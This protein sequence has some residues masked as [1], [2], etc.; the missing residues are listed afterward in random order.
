MKRTIGEYLERMAEEIPL[1]IGLTIAGVGIMGCLA[2][3]TTLS[4]DFAGI[5]EP[6]RIGLFDKKYHMNSYTLSEIVKAA[7]LRAEG[8]VN[9]DR[10]REIVIKDGNDIIAFRLDTRSYF[11]QESDC[12]EKAGTLEGVGRGVARLSLEDTDKD[13][14]IDLLLNMKDNTLKQYSGKS[15]VK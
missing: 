9:G 2:I 6:H 13:G 4:Y 15:L 11:A 1:P 5:G 14:C 10:I 8:D 7:D 12:Y 3:G